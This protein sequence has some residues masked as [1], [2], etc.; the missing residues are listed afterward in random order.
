MTRCL[1][2]EELVSLY[3]GEGPG[4][5][6][7]HLDACLPCTARYGRLRSD[8]QVVGR[9]LAGERPSISGRRPRIVS[10]RW[11]MPAA[12]AA[13]AALFVGSELVTSS[14]RS[15]PRSAGSAPGGTVE[16]AVALDGAGLCGSVEMLLGVECGD[17]A[18]A[19][20]TVSLALSDRDLWM[21]ED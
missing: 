2:E 4:A 16:Q 7:D 8:L 5:H 18:G 17:S 21:I 15:L 11:W 19:D 10:P 3:E 9:V 1:T 13:V 14:G 6:R 20:E 12:A